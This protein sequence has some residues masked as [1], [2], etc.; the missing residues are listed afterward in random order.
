MKFTRKRYNDGSL[1]KWEYTE[2]LKKVGH[3]LHTSKVTWW[4]ICAIWK[5]HT[6][7]KTANGKTV[8]IAIES[9][10]LKCSV[11]FLFAI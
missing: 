1:L 7:V 4:K 8:R 5:G 11:S 6:Y 10:S 2:L 9:T 3:Q